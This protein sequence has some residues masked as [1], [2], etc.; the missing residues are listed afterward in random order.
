MQGEVARIA[1]IRAQSLVRN[2]E[3]RRNPL[4][5]NPQESI[6]FYI[7][8][9]NLDTISQVSQIIHHNLSEAI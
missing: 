9:I 7:L 8:S 6:V 2:T 5:L 1:T 4:V 3:S